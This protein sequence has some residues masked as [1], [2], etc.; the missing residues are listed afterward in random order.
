MWLV[1]SWGAVQPAGVMFGNPVA[2]IVN[3][4]PQLPDGVL[5]KTPWGCP[6]KHAWHVCRLR[7]ALLNHSLR[8]AWV[9]DSVL[10]T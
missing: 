10:A 1:T 8:L 7:A 6:L 9:P 3:A 4:V 2:C 5:D